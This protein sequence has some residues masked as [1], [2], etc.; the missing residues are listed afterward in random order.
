MAKERY[1]RL[2]H[3]TPAKTPRHINAEF[4]PEQQRYI[5]AVNPHN[6][7]AGLQAI[8]DRDLARTAAEKEAQA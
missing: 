8:V 6:W 7:T 5:H 2:R 1:T 3:N 4:T